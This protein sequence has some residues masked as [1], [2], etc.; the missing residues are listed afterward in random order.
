MKKGERVEV[1]YDPLTEN[2]L[3]GKAQ[4]LEE[5]AESVGTWNGRNLTEWRVK[6]ADGAKVIRKIL[7]PAK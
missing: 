3:E 7:E 1:Y 5:L 2:E 6:F 4:L